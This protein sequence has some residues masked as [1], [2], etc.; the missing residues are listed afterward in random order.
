VFRRGLGV[1]VILAGLVL[2]G[3]ACGGGDDGGSSYKEP[4]GPAVADLAFL[5]ENFAFDPEK[6]TAPPGVIDITLESTEG[7][8]DLVIEGVPGFRLVTPGS[9]DTDSGKVDLKKKKYT[10]YC[11]LPGHRAAGMVGTLTVG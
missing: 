2:G 1:V 3:A 5:A 6:A 7:G 9:G 8:H 4:T 11:S 10:F